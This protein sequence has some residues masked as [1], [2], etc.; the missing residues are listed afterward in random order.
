MIQSRVVAYS[1]RG[2]KLKSLSGSLPGFRIRKA[3]RLRE[4]KSDGENVE[5]GRF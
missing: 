3:H 5:K 2:L 4:C 1:K